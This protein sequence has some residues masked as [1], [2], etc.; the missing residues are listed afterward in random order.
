MGGLGLERSWATKLG[1]K[2]GQSPVFLL[3]YLFL[4]NS[5]FSIFNASSFN[6]SLECLSVLR[7]SVNNQLAHTNFL[8]FMAFMLH[9]LCSLR[10][11]AH[12]LGNACSQN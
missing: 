3:C 4:F 1:A 8:H 12:R 6:D 5:F 10:F 2:G 7:L 9:F 11:T